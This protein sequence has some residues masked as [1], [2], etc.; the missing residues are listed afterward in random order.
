M[1]SQDEFGDPRKRENVSP[2]P[3]PSVTSLQVRACV[4]ECVCAE[5]FTCHLPVA[6]DCGGDFAQ[7]G[8]EVRALHPPEVG[9]CTKG[10]E[11]AQDKRA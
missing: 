6:H 11:G 7:A 3:D 4:R 1:L 5:G 8:R 9:E 10:Q 2:E